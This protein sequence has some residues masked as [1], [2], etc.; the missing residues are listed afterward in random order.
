MAEN[1]LFEKYGQTVEPGRVIFEENDEGQQMFI[2]QD[3]IVRI[4]KTI[5]GQEHVLAELTKGDFFGEM[6]IVTRVRRTATATAV[7]RVQLLT[8]DRAGFQGMI[9]KNSRIGLNIIDKLCRRLQHANHQIE[10]L[11]Q[12]N[13]LSMVAMSLYLRFTEKGGEEPFMALDRSVEELSTSLGM[14]AQVVTG[15][16]NKLAES[17]VIT[18]NSNAIRLKD[19]GKLAS[20]VERLP[21]R[22]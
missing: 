1:V 17:E 20:L 2:I 13:E 18:L 12:R 19:Q 8:F 22:R 15:H 16:I 21:T 11:F 6:A 4:S 14:P 3:G 10:Q 7:G 9:E 5:D